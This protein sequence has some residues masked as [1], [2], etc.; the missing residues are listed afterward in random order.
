MTD[1]R[2][3]LS[4]SAAL[5]LAAA[6][7]LASR[8]QTAW[9]G[10]P[11]RVVIPYAAGGV[12]D[13]VG[14]RLL[15]QMSKALGQAF[16]VENKGGAGGT[17]GM[18]EVAK[19]QPDGYTLAL[20]AISPLTLSPHLMKLPYDP[21][22]DIV[23][24]APM[25]YSP[26][27]VLGT[28]AFTGKSWEDLIAQAKAKPDTL[29][30]ATSG[31]GSVGHIMLEQIQHKTGARFVHI[32]YKGVGQTVNDAVGGHFEIMTANP[33]GTIN[34]LIAQGKLQVLATT[35][36]QR[37]PN[38][39][40]IATLAEKGVPEANITSMFGFMAPARTPADIVQRL[41]AVVREQLATPTIQE[42]LRST[43]NVGLHLSAKEFGELLQQESRNNA[44]IIQKAAITL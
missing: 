35:G 18:A 7:P 8:A 19:A 2:H 28:S 21:A 33:F 16:V 36:P 11:I 1:R 4:H 39:P 29:R 41:N 34:G 22:K 31:V 44:D 14:R 13:S 26:V 10:K 9:P 37:A 30:F 38:Q 27:Y 24:V 3:F 5:T 25:M 40:Q 23:S 43:D 20:S 32:P 12:T 6:L 15:D 42:A 17:V